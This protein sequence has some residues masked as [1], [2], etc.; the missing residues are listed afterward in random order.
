[1]FTVSIPWGISEPAALVG[2]G[3]FSNGAPPLWVFDQILTI[4]RITLTW[5]TPAKSAWTNHCSRPQV[6]CT[7]STEEVCDSNEQAF[8]RRERFVQLR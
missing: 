3:A 5:F 2:A 6:V 1:V 7:N 4:W 8:N